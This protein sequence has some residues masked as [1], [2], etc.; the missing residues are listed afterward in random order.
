MSDRPPERPRKGPLTSEFWEIPDEVDDPQWAGRR[1]ASEAARRIAHNLVIT[2]ADPA[3]L[4]RVA[5]LLEEAAD[6]L[7]EAPTWTVA[8]AFAEGRLGQ[9]PQQ[10]ADRQSI[11]GRANPFAPPLRL[12]RQGDRVVGHVTFDHAHGGAPGWVHGGIVAAVFD[13][14]MGYVLI[15]EGVP[16]VTASIEVRYE[17]PTRLHVPLTVTA[18][19]VGERAHHTLVEAEL[20]D[21]EQV[22]A[23]ATGDFVRLDPARFRRIA[24]G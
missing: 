23:R 2:Y 8:E 19:E 16:C 18:W 12:S 7:A 24:L 1:R 15:T 4:D 13:Q 9:S 11:I 10:Y 21:G 17:K 5:A 14:A 22:V 6:L 3:R 20:R